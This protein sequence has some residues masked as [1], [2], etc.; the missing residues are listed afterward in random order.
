MI[1]VIPFTGPSEYLD[2]LS[3][4]LLKLGGLG[5]HR[6]IVPAPQNLLAGAEAFVS[7][8]RSQFVAAE[9]APTRTPDSPVVRLFRDGLMAGA[10]VKSSMQEIPN[11]PVLWIEPGFIPTKADWADGIQS[12]FFNTGGGLRILA[13]WR[14][15]PDMTVGNGNARHVIPGG[16]EPTGPAVFPAGWVNSCEMV[17]RI[18]DSSSPWRERLQFTFSDIRAESPLL[19]DS[20]ESL[21]AAYEASAKPTAKPKTAPV[22]A[23]TSDDVVSEV[24]PTDTPPIRRAASR[25][26]AAAPTADPT[27]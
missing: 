21:L 8:L 1:L 7:G 26:F 6:L 25:S 13:S 4:R 2:E 9:V 16:W 22:V 12:A 10:K 19:S 3:A 14:K 27:T 24:T 18:N 23:E 5:G 17:H 11:A 20:S 15:R